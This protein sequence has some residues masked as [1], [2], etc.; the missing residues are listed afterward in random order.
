MPLERVPFT[1]VLNLIFLTAISYSKLFNKHDTN[2]IGSILFWL[3]LCFGSLFQSDWQ[4]S[5]S[6]QGMIFSLKKKQ[7]ASKL[8]YSFLTRYG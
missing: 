1:R 3:R 6:N 2:S 4:N 5:K 7:K 8:T